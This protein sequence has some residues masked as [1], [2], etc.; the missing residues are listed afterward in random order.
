MGN[1]L[2]AVINAGGFGYFRETYFNVDVGQRN[3]K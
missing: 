3:A 2:L 1:F